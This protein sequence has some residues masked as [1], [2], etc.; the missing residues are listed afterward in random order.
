MPR[1][2]S[3]FRIISIA[4]FIQWKLVK[5]TSASGALHV[6]VLSYE[7]SRYLSRHVK[8]NCVIANFYFKNLPTS[9][10]VNWIFI[11]NLTSTVMLKLCFFRE[12]TGMATVNQFFPCYFSLTM[13]L[14]AGSDA[15]EQDGRWPLHHFVKRV[16]LDFAPRRHMSSPC[17]LSPLYIATT[18]GK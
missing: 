16:R 7:V 3:N 1:W 2:P 9:L 10:I 8:C 4:G 17:H 6:P 12:K 18:L 13:F 14:H 15:T 11:C 5:Q